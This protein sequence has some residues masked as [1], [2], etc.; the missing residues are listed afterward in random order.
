MGDMVELLTVGGELVGGGGKSGGSG[1]RQRGGRKRQWIAAEVTRIF[2]GGKSG[3]Y[4]V[5]ASDISTLRMQF[6]RWKVG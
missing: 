6:P 4:A 1:K 3:K 2:R 5:H